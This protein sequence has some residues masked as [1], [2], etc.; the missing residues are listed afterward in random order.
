MMFVPSF[1]TACRTEDRDTLY[2]DS[3]KNKKKKYFVR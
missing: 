3:K 1:V 2:N